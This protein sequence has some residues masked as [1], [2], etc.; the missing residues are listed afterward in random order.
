MTTPAKHVGVVLAAGGSSRLGQPKQLLRRDG[1]TLIHRTVRLVATTGAERIVVVLG[2]GHERFA[3]ELADLPCTIV[4][5]AGWSTG[6]AG[7]L[8][9]AAPHVPADA[10]ALIVACDQPALE[11][12]HLH[13]LLA[14][15]RSV[16]SHGAATDTGR[17]IGV[18]AVVPGAW[19]ADMQ[20]TGDHG[21]R[22][23]LRDLAPD[24]VFRLHAPDLARDIDTP[25]DLQEAIAAGWLD[26]VATNEPH[27]NMS[28]L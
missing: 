9:S 25:A 18:P 23:R 7:S 8:R 2:A 15:A 20:A 16:A 24:A 13:A 11:S 10:L 27:H 19:F 21:F 28:P 5:N 17:V 12:H 4:V 6:I 1:E 3:D 22:D 26:P 14:G